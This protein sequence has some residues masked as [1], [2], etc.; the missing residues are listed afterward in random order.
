MCCKTVVSTNKQQSRKVFAMQTHI[1]EFYI[2][3]SFMSFVEKCQPD[4]ECAVKRVANVTFIYDND[5]IN[6]MQS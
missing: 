3:R 4:R 5:M 1:G 6:K 2:K